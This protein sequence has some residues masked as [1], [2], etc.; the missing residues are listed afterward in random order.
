MFLYQQDIRDRFIEIL[1]ESGLQ[2]SS[3]PE[4]RSRPRTS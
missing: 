1:A 2:A 3:F 4:H